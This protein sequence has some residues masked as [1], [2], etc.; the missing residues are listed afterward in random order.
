ML[1]L[2]LGFPKLGKKYEFDPQIRRKA[3]LN[4]QILRRGFIQ[5]LGLIFTSICQWK[6]FFLNLQ[7]HWLSSPL[8]VP[9]LCVGPCS[10]WRPKALFYPYETLDDQNWQV[11]KSSHW[12]C[13][14]LP[15]WLEILHPEG[16]CGVSVGWAYVSWFLL[17]S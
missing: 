13:F 1:F 6:D 16:C 12:I 14:H 11:L 7:F 2:G 3:V 4:L 15:F 17:R 10:L 9:A 5:D 8:K